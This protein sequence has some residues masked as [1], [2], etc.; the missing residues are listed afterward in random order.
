M[1][2]RCQHLQLTK[3]KNN[4]DFII[5]IGVG[6]VIG[7]YITTQLGKVLETNNNN[8]VK[9]I[10]AYEQKKKAE[11]QQSKVLAKRQTRRTKNKKKNINV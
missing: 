8:L 10:E 4:M 2:Q 6:I 9:N 1:K 11:Q 7:M 3:E 5:I